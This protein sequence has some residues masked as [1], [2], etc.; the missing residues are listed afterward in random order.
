M[1]IPYAKQAWTDG[2]GGGTPV[3]AARLAVIE[4]GVFDAHYQPAVRAFHSA[5]QSITSATAT[6]L[7]FNSDRFDQASNASDTMHDTVTNNSRLTC[8]YAGVYLI[9]ANVEWAASTAGTRTI[10]IRHSTGSTAI[11]VSSIQSPTSTT[12]RQQAMTIYSMAV[13]DYVECVV[14]QDTG[15]ALNVLATGNYSPEF[16]MV[17]V[18]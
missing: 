7:A 12:L 9:W 15:G 14:T 10:N 4:Q 18:G 2:S 3:S 5:N 11:G 8:R 6:A 13:N 16:A 1:A 17:R